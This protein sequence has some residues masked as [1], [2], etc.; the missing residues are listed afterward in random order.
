MKLSLRFLL[1]VT[2]LAP[3]V[4]AQKQ[5]QADTTI[6]VQTTLIQV[7]VTVV[8]KKGMPV[9][10]LKKEDFVLKENGKEVPVAVFEEVKNAT[11][12]IQ[13]PKLPPGQYTNQIVPNNDQRNVLLFAID[14][15]YTDPSF[16]SFGRL[17]LA[18]YLSTELKP[19]TLVGIYYI[20]SSGVRV[21]HD[22]SSDSTKLIA[23]LQGYK[24]EVNR[25]ATTQPNVSELLPAA[26]PLA[27]FDPAPAVDF[28]DSGVAEYSLMRKEQQANDVFE[29][30]RMLARSVA[31]I[32]GRKSLIL[33]TYGLGFNYNGADQNSRL[34]DRVERM[35]KDLNDANVAVYPYLLEGLPASSPYA[36]AGKYQPANNTGSG[37]TNPGSMS[38]RSGDRTGS[39]DLAA[40][41]Q[42]LESAND[43]TGDDSGYSIARMTG[44]KKCNRSN[45]ITNCMDTIMRDSS[46]YYMLGYYLD[47]KDQKKSEDRK[48]S[49]KV[50]QP[51][52]VVTSHPDL[53]LMNAKEANIGIPWPDANYAGLSK[54]TFTEMPVTVNWSPQAGAPSDFSISIPG[55]KVKLN[56]KNQVSM[57]FLVVVRNAKGQIVDMVHE[58][59]Q[60]DV[61]NVESFRSRNQNYSGKLKPLSGDGN[62]RF[63]A[64]D[65]MS[66]KVG[67]VDVPYKDGK[68]VPKG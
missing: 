35:F 24:P 29:S 15:V 8:D 42:Q 11:E 23:D 36:I 34:R 5:D 51:G 18:H 56:E 43:S 3:L 52:A 13:R 60:G 50:N 22:V 21:I 61:S 47:Q 27:N 54:L 41:M 68:V 14:G 59:L 30:V 46:G 58:I 19:G 17:A 1:S 48:I 2:L 62:V 39:A 31:G 65:G 64:V 25:S 6:K 26:S 7:P 16:Q 20:T 32:P 66:R 49:V 57:D 28:T 45:E 55:N 33:M 63:I 38:R 12:P 10:G 4:T 53:F 44:G 40:R 67:T 9:A 37:L